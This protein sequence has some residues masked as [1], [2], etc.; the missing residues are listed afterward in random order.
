MVFLFKALSERGKIIEFTLLVGFTLGMK[1]LLVGLITVFTSFSLWAQV[2]VSQ[3][4]AVRDLDQICQTIYEKY[5]YFQFKQNSLKFSWV[6]KCNQ[7]KSIA[8]LRSQGLTRTEF[9]I[10]VTDLLASFKDS[11]TSLRSGFGPEV[12]LFLGIQ[13]QYVEDL[14]WLRKANSLILNQLGLTAGQLEAQKIVLESIQGV[15]LKNLAEVFP[16]VG[17]QAEKSNY[18]SFVNR[19]NGQTAGDFFKYLS[20]FKIIVPWSDTLKLKLRSVLTGKTYNVEYP[21][22]KLQQQEVTA[23]QAQSCIEEEGYRFSKI[24][25]ST[26]YLFAPTWMAERIECDEEL[27]KFLLEK[28]EFLK[29]QGTNV[30]LIIDVRYNSGGSHMWHSFLRQFISKEK[31][32][33][34]TSTVVYHKPAFAGYH[35]NQNGVPHRIVDGVARPLWFTD[36]CKSTDYKNIPDEELKRVDD[37][38][39]LYPLSYLKYFKAE[40]YSAAHVCFLE[41]VENAY[42]G[43]VAVLADRH[44]YS[45]NDQFLSAIKA[46]NPQQIKI[47][48]E[49]SRAGSGGGGELILAESKFRIAYSVFVDWNYKSDLIEGFGMKP[50]VSV[51]PTIDSI[52]QQKDLFVDEALRLLESL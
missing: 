14:F 29:S 8:G 15:S 24:A 4:Q 36:S 27:E 2:F 42:K 13:I 46:V 47:I 20:D 30:N 19:L 39:N 23:E 5:A 35:L 43:K 51:T 48:G 9:G 45:S 7:A 44:A 38:L 10:L 16:F 22:V 17:S 37:F 28:M 11:H 6:D 18:D 33:L 40:T 41:P 3:D 32:N 52:L 50:D 1:S 25:D 31:G 34:V 12:G 49:P 26:Y 21:W